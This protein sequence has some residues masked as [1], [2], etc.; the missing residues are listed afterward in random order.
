M[1]GGRSGGDSGGGGGG[2]GILAGH[3]GPTWRVLPGRRLRRDGE[4]AHR[5]ERGGLGEMEGWRDGHSG[6][7][8]LD[9]TRET[10]SGKGED[11]DLPVIDSTPDLFQLSCDEGT[12]APSETMHHSSSNKFQQLGSLNN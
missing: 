5:R 9:R 11:D 10:S 6:R 4:R 3:T 12:R 1:T 8:K 7:F 2:G